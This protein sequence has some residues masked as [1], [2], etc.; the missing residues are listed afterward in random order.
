MKS[1]S[2]TDLAVFMD[3]AV[4]QWH[5][6]EELAQRLRASGALELDERQEWAPEPGALYFVRRTASSLIAFRPGVCSPSEA[7]FAL[8][9]AHTDSP[10][11]RVRFGKTLASRGMIRLPVEIYGGPIISTW[12]DRPLSLA[13]RVILRSGNS[14]VSRLYRS[15]NAIGI[16]PNLA[17]HLNREINKGIEYNPQIQLPVLVS[18]SGGGQPTGPDWV[19]EK[20]AC[21][22]G[23]E[24]SCIL[25]CDLNFFEDVPAFSFGSRGVPDGET[26]VDVS[27][28][29]DPS[30]SSIP[31]SSKVESVKN[32]GF[33]PARTLI[34]SG[35]LDDLA[36]CHAIL[37]AL[38]DSPATPWA[39]VGCF[40]DA[41][42]IGSRTVAGADSSFIRDTLARL[43][44]VSGGGREGYYRA[45]AHSFMLS[46]DAAQ[47]WH[48]AWTEK[49]D[50]AYTPAVGQGVAIK[51]NAMH[52][53][54]TN[55][56]TEAAFR[57]YCSSAGVNCQMYRAR[58]DLVPGSTIGPMSSALT[59]IRTV[60]IGHPLLSMH[61]IRE[62]ISLEDHEDMTK[63]VSA[64]F[65]RMAERA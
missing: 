36:G 7:G 16:I 64:H 61:S 29:P 13:G 1:V 10:A 42:E 50:E 33:D 63:V 24:P 55:A 12:L 35:R 37:Q 58:A 38:L 6:T 43:C 56:E 57:E 52:K 39:Q 15:R 30:F 8:A 45:S 26:L 23:V 54:A 47:A 62:T 49:F 53:Y 4:T 27:N 22:M 40:M 3:A 20:L 14:R 5:A 44:I 59:G 51:A 19:V 60:D 9:G 18:C 34:N 41:E 2:S 17:I 21:D 28:M 65:S 48:P 31:G 25:A 46:V 32:D 11:L